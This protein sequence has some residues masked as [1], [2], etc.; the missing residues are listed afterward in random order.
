ML[1]QSGTYNIYAKILFTDNFKVFSTPTYT[2]TINNPSTSSSNNNNLNNY[3][4]FLEK[5]I[6]N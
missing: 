1:T 5:Y 2:L 4:Q 3:E 6:K